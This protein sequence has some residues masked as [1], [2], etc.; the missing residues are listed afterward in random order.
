MDNCATVRTREQDDAAHSLRWSGWSGVAMLT[1]IVVNGPLASLR[2]F[3]SYWSHDA[4]TNVQA[5]LSDPSSLRLAVFF[6]FFSTLIFVFAIPFFAGLREL[7][8]RSGTSC[9]ASGAVT[10]GAALFLAGGLV[11]EVMAAGMASVVQAAPA[12]TVDA[13]AALGIMGL[14]FAALI[15][16]QVGLGIAIIAVSMVTRHG[17]LAPSG[18]ATL[19]LVAGSIDILR[20]LAVTRPPIAIA[21]FV[22]TMLWLAWTSVALIRS[23]QT[24][25]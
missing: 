17:S 24:T 4:A 19:G 20:P 23:Q 18:L 13:N 25:A 10:I 2:G 7:V 1:V 3:P 16:G 22:P 8:Q 5:Y 6:F 12:Y 21:L 9:L 11:S 15:Q 14:Q